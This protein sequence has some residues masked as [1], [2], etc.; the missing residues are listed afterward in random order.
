MDEYFE[1]APQQGAYRAWARKALAPIAARVGWDK[2]AGE[3]DNVGLLRNAV[4]GALSEFDDPQVIAEARRRFAGYLKDPSSLTPSTRH[5]VLRIVALHADAQTWDALHTLAKTAPTALTKDE[6]YNFLALAKDP[7]LARRALDLAVSGEPE[8]TE[9]PTMIRVVSY[10]HAAAAFDFYLAHRAQVDQNLEPDSRNQFAP[11]LVEEANDP[12]LGERL[13][14]YARANI[15]ATARGS[16]VKAQ[17]ALR[18]RAEVK[19][20]RTPEIAAWIAQR[21]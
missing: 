11:N 18:Y 10:Q 5:T 6:Y 19:R 12:A 8:A 1:G 9:G 4:L 17:S 14:A 20:L 7:A 15:P 2:A 3:S 21:G 13:E 16:V